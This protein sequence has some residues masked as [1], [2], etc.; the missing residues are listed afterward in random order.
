MN[1]HTQA[2]PPSRLDHVPNKLDS[3]K[4][5]PGITGDPNMQLRLLQGVV[6]PSV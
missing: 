4:R 2:G 6:V 5:D 1:L 3:L